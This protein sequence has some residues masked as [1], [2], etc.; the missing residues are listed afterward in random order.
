MRILK[1]VAPLLVISILL[2][3]LFV[4]P[5]NTVNA[6]A[7]EEEIVEL[8][9]N[10]KEEIIEEAT[11]DEIIPDVVNT[12]VVTSVQNTPT[13]TIQKPIVK[14][15]LNPNIQWRSNLNIKQKLLSL[16][17]SE[18]RIYDP[19][20]VLLHF[21]SN[22]GNN[23]QNPYDINAVHSIL[24]DYELSTHYT[25]D[26]DGT[27]YLFTS[28]DRVA[29][30]AGKGYLPDYPEYENRLNH[31]SI[32]IEILGIGTSSEMSIMLSSEQFN[33]IDPSL[34]GYTDAQYEALNL[35][36]D[37]ILQRHSSIK[38]DRRHI[39]GHDEYNPSKTDPGSLFNWNKIGL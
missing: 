5:N 34:L 18:E 13:P 26:R 12:E 21:I 19:T 2:V 3:I 23:Q 37:D 4:P 38:K 6:T 7:T 29:Y 17:N 14:P 10:I 22:A 25:I 20:H 33:A 36:L 31:H 28:E 39:L 27:I 11:V 35:L 24:N 16:N 32:G 15:I 30:H 1:W 8:T 9:P